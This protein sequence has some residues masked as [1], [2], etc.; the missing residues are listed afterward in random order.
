MSWMDTVLSR[1]SLLS[2]QMG[3]WGRPSK[4]TRKPLFQ[5]HHEALTLKSSM[6]LH[7]PRTYKMNRIPIGVRQDDEASVTTMVKELEERS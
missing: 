5:H 1:G 7:A 3:L 6:A 4:P 2:E